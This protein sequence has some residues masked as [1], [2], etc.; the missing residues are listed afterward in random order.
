MTTLT[1]LSEIEKTL[2]ISSV[3]YNIYSSSQLDLSHVLTLFQQG[4]DEFYQR[5][6]KSGV[7]A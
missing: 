5:D 2:F 3:C 7:K 4:R 1:I 6:I